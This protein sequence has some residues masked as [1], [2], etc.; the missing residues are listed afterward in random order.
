MRVVSRNFHGRCDSCSCVPLRV[1]NPCESHT[2]Q[3][4]PAVRFVPSWFPATG[5][6]RELS[7]MRGTL[8][9]VLTKPINFVK[10][11]LVGNHLN[12]LFCMLTGASQAAGT[13]QPSFVASQLQRPDWNETRE[14]DM[15][16]WSAEALYTGGADTS[17]SIA[18]S[19]LLA[20][21][22]FPE[23]QKKGQEE[24]DS[25]CGDQLPTWADRERLPYVSAILTEALRWGVVSP[26]ALPHCAL[27]DDEYL[28]YT[29]K[30]G[31]LL[32][33]N[34][35]CVF[36]CIDDRKVL[37]YD[38][39]IGVSPATRHITRTPKSSAQSDI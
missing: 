37:A 25:V 3:T 20:M 12:V 36:S 30:K 24:I 29:I 7:R 14:R 6:K 13:A 11:Q 8:D 38:Q 23:V 10:E 32:V 18:Y 31:T 9:E 26:Q 19:F 39:T 15:L 17:I 33:P 1:A 16:A 21:L 35:W 28:G 34:I 4:L 2:H 22:L 5:W 27:K